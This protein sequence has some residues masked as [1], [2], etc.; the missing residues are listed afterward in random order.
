MWLVLRG[1]DS[2][3]PS[4]VDV[5]GRYFHSITGTFRFAVLWFLHY[6]CSLSLVN[7]LG[8]HYKKC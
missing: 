5:R 1:Q 8:T 2:L 6:I 4:I 7:Q 3:Y